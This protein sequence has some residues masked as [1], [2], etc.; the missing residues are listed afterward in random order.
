MIKTLLRSAVPEAF[1]VGLLALLVVTKVVAQSPFI[2][3]ARF[4]RLTLEDGLSQSSVNCIVQDHQGFLW[5]GTQDGLNRYDGYEFRTFH[6]DDQV[7]GSISNNFVWALHVDKS[8]ALWVGTEGGG[9]DRWNPADDSFSHYRHD[10]DNPNSLVHDEIW[11]ISEDRDGALWVGT[12]GGL[13]RFSPGSGTFTHFTH[14]ETD[15]SSL[16]GNQVRS[17]LLDSEKRLWV[18]TYEG[19][20]SRKDPGTGTFIKYRHDPENTNSL[21]SNKIRTVLEDR[22]GIIWIGTYD[23]GLNR[24]DPKTNNIE[25]Y[26]TDPGTNAGQVEDRVR[27]LFSDNTGTLWVGTDVG[28]KRLLE[29]TGQFVTYH[30]D[31]ADPNSLGSDRILSIYQDQGGLLWVATQAGLTHRNPAL[32]T[33]A[34]LKQKAD[35]ENTLSSNLITS[36]SQGPDRTLW[37]GTYGGGLTGLDLDSG[38]FRHLR[39]DG[40]NP[41]SLGDDRV[42]SLFH[43][44]KGNLWVGSLA[45]GLGVRYAGQKGFVHFKNDPDDPASLSFNGVTAITEGTDGTIWVGT[46]GGG[47]NRL[48]P[49]GNSFQRFGH[50]PEDPDSL[51][52]DQVMSLYP[53]DDGRVWIGTKAGGLNLLDPETG[54]FTHYRHDPDDPHSIGSDTIWTMHEDAAGTMWFGTQGGGLNR[55]NRK[56]RIAGKGLFRRYTVRDGLANDFIYGILEDEFGD[57]WLSS[58]KGISRFNTRAEVFTNFNSTHGLQSLEFNFGAYFRNNSGD[59]FFGGNNGFNHFQPSDVRRNNHIP[60]VVLTG[61]LKMNERVTLDRPSWELEELVVDHHDQVISFDFSAL[62]YSA[63]EKNRYAYRL[64]GFDADWIDLGNMRRATFTNLDAGEYTLMVRASNND[65]VWN[66]AGIALPIRVLPPPWKSWW[67]YTLYALA[68]CAL[69]LGIIG[70]QMRKLRREE[71]HSRHLE[72]CVRERTEELA[73]RN[74]ELATFN[75]K[76]EKASLTDALT[77]LRNRRYFQHHL[78]EDIALIDRRFEACRLGRENGDLA[79]TGLLCLMIDLDGFKI[80]ND[81]FGHAAGDRVL[82]E[83]CNALSTIV[84]QSDTVIRWGG[85]EFMVLARSTG[86][87]TAHVLAE[88]IRETIAG[89]KIRVDGDR[90]AQVG[91]SL[92]YAFY[93]FLPSA[94]RLMM[95]E[96]VLKVA[97]RALYMAKAS[98]KDAWV[99]ISGREPARRPAF[100]DNLLADPESLYRDGA[101]V[102]SSNLEVDVLWAAERRTVKD[103]RAGGESA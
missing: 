40:K 35:T 41:A 5:F 3:N 90:I 50:D 42:M 70:V 79:N 19:G 59:M 24:L 69:V 62:D 27:A 48:L 34:H 64:E 39:H 9:L 43:D 102:V 47:L 84:R 99:G 66:E 101:I 13:S 46:Y 54:A 10:P 4:N 85:D 53:G 30:H 25:R 89:L 45:G 63:P 36:F 95:W 55:W 6:H 56:D 61:I 82:V 75:D 93:P 68:L 49:D 57:L 52:A 7:P 86:R 1:S 8:G 16:S 29:E 73:E 78:Q 15:S 83:T 23:R 92:G 26:R 17:I 100:L 38:V 65:D 98:G 76:L 77:G 51:S 28:L 88:R 33:F 22:R 21:S 37:I 11:A 97:D 94:P 80:I 60:P 32:E 12:G 18:G 87:D 58:N 2:E 20:L 74:R 31:P 81:T 67:A 72:E 44:G 91:C 71:E 103:R 96:Q 14:D